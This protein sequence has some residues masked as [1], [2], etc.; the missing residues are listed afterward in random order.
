MFGGRDTEVR[1]FGGHET[2]VPLSSTVLELASVQRP[3]LLLPCLL[4]LGQLLREIEL[5]LAVIVELRMV[6]VNA[7][8]VCLAGNLLT[9]IASDPFRVLMAL[10]VVAGTGK[11]L[12]A[13]VNAPRLL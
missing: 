2:E 12:V 3:S 7:A 13:I 9:A 8:L 5:V 10:A 1:L 11:I 4:T 6:I